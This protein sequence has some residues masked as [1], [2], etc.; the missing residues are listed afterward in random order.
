VKNQDT[1]API[2][3]SDN[4]ST[5]VQPFRRRKVSER[6]KCEG[7][8]RFKF[9][10]LQFCLKMQSETE[11]K[12]KATATTIPTTSVYPELKW[13][14][15]PS[16]STNVF[17]GKQLL[18]LGDYKNP[19][20][21]QKGDMIFILYVISQEECLIEVTNE[22]N[23]VEGWFYRGPFH[24]YAS[25]PIKA[26]SNLGLD[27][28]FKWQFQQTATGVQNR[29]QLRLRIDA[30]Q[31]ATEDEDLEESRNKISS[32]DKKRFV[33]IPMSRNKKIDA[34]RAY[35][36]SLAIQKDSTRKREVLQ[37]L[38]G[39]RNSVGGSKRGGGRGGRGK[40]R[41]RAFDLAALL[42]MA[43]LGDTSP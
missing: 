26:V 28:A 24:S 34:L 42:A 1:A 33:Y 9:L 41:E 8:I 2:P 29:D 10:S 4:F 39:G 31:C 27:G 38:T 36:V 6:E 11:S 30:D 12:P 37:R 14:D 13:V 43:K 17:E 22:S 20:F 32:T 23:P 3:N 7:V 21:Y 35:I 18:D 5:W 15:V 19:A 40:G 16:S 25:G